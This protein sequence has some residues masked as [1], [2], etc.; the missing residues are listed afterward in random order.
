MSGFEQLLALAAGMTVWVAVKWLMV[1]GL[2][3]YGVFAV[4]VVRQVQLMSRA[5]H[6]GLEWP[7]KIGAIVHAGIAGV[8]LVAAIVIL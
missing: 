7:L 4:V 8:A 1:L 3:I 5:V 2:I 6:G